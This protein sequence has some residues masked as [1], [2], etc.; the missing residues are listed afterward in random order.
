V[1]SKEVV[2]FESLIQ[3]LSSIL[4][5]PKAKGL[6]HIQVM[7]GRKCQEPLLVKPRKVTIKPIHSF[8]NIKSSSCQVKQSQTLK[9]E[10]SASFLFSSFE[11]LCEGYKSNLS[12]SRVDAFL[13][14]RF[15]RYK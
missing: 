9:Q 15:D 5:L 13:T 8:F 6:N 10:S 14:D 12:E 2:H 3:S 7:F 11:V 1:L 4:L